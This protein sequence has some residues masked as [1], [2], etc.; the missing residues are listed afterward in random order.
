LTR[1]GIIGRFDG[2]IGGDD[3][4]HGKPNPDPYV[5]AAELAGFPPDECLAVEDSINGIRSAVTAGIRCVYI[6][7]FLDIP[8]EIEA[9]AYKKVNS[10]DK[11]IDIIIQENQSSFLIC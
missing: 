1:T 10:L 9:I 4:E 7:D 8:E 5:K 6:K 11:I 2:I 3:V